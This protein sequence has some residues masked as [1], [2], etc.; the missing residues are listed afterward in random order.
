MSRKSPSYGHAIRIFLIIGVAL[1]VALVVR[2][3]LVPE[4]F[5]EIGHYRA[6]A[7]DEARR[8]TPRHVGRETCDICHDD[9][10]ALHAKDAHATVSCE[11]CHGP[12]QAH[13]DAEGE[14]GIVRPQG[15]PACLVCHQFMPARPGEFAQIVPA[16]HYEFVGVAEPQ[17]ACT[18]CHD[19]HEPLYM[20]RDLRT[21]RLHPLIH[22]CRDCHTG[23]T[24]ESLPR[25][26][27]HPAIFE[28]D[29]CHA[30]IV[31]GFQERPHAAMRCTAC[32]VFIRESEFAGRI[33]RDADPRFCLLCHRETDF[34]SADAAPGITWPDHR[35]MMAMDDADLTKRCVDCHQDRIHPL[36]E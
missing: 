4:S 13:V 18:A 28:C 25:P 17:T 2:S 20:D 33:V 3:Q 31:S 11:S 23:R 8:F 29:Y 12:G 21:A 34:R 14:G 7:L 9:V 16:D 1:V 35:E 5:G 6:A 15:Q 30:P 19:P 27:D 22:R 32:H 26:A 36:Q 10:V 24:D